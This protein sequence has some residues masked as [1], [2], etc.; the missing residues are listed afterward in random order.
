MRTQMSD[1]DWEVLNWF[2]SLDLEE[3]SLY[4][5]KYFGDYPTSLLD[6]KMVT[7]MYEKENTNN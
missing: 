4:T 5:K 2:T 1:Y 7:E 6:D 3:I